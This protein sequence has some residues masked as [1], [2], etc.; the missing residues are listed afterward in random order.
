MASA[1]SLRVEAL[2]D[3]ESS[4]PLEAQWNQLWNESRDRTPFQSFP[5]VQALFQK[6]EH[7]NPRVLLARDSGQIVGILP[8]VGTEIVSLAGGDVSDYC[9]GVFADDQASNAITSILSYLFEESPGCREVMFDNVRERSAL[10]FGTVEGALSDYVEV[11]NTCPVLPLETK[12]TECG[13]LETIPANQRKKVQYYLRRA[14]KAGDLQFEHVSADTLDL[15]LD[16]FF[17]LHRARWESRGEPGVLKNNRIQ[18]FHRQAAPGLLKLGALRMYTLR[19]DGRI[20]AIYLGFLCARRAYFYLSGFDP[21]TSA[22]NP[23]TLLVGHA[24]AEA[25]HER[26]VSFDFLRGCEPYKYEWGARN[27]QTFRRRFQR[28]G[29]R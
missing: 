27:T 10:L 1:A 6:F 17:R 11:Q 8:V 14:Q 18:E 12:G 13:A 5:W 20:I 16:A 24:I 26:A 28:L 4:S 19:L 25:A 29:N 21:E 2:S 3:I 9:D 23:G 7:Q 22:L 15:Y